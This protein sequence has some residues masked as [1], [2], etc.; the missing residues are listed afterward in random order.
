MKPLLLAATLVSVA[1]NLQALERPTHYQ[2]IIVTDN[3]SAFTVLKTGNQQLAQLL[4]LELNAHNMNE[5]HK[6]TYTLENALASIASA[7][8]EMK[9]VLEE[10]HLGSE[11]M[12]IERV[13]NHGA[14]YLKLTK[15][16]LP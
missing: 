5:I 11:T 9:E 14:Y 4:S 12:D 2:G 3:E 6:L 13:K 7:T 16:L 10:V 8:E 15:T 1:L